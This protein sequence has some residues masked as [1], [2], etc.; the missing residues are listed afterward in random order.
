[1]DLTR[2]LNVR[3]TCLERLWLLSIDFIDDGAF[4]HIYKPRRRVRMSAG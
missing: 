3:L 1:M 4:D 2:H